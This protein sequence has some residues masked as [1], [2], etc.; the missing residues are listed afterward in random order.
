METGTIHELL[1]SSVHMLRVEMPCH[2]LNSM[3]KAAD[4]SPYLVFQNEHCTMPLLLQRPCDKS[5]PFIAGLVVIIM[6][7]PALSETYLVFL[8]FRPFY[9]GRFLYHP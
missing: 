5:E 1:K 9:Q 6:L 8:G 2:Y 7:F 3:G 4:N